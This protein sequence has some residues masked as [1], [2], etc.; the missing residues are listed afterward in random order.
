VYQVQAGS[1]LMILLMCDTSYHVREEA[2][3][4]ECNLDL[5]VGNNQTNRGIKNATMVAFCGT[6]LLEDAQE[7]LVLVWVQ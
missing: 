1:K 2:K 6:V 3:S 7:H 4:R 5:S